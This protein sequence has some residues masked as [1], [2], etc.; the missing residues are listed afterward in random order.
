L[1]DK[2]IDEFGEDSTVEVRK[3][4]QAVTEKGID[5]PPAWQNID[6]LQLKGWTRYASAIWLWTCRVS[7]ISI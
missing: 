1:V 5:V 6:F 4:F 2:S 7:Q 3:G